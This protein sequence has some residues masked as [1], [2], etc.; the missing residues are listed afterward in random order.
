MTATAHHAILRRD[1]TSFATLSELFDDT[2][3]RH[4]DRPA[5][6]SADCTLT[7]AELKERS[8]ALAERLALNGAGRGDLVGLIADRSVEAVVG[9]LTILRA[10]AAYVPLDTSYPPERM[11][12]MLADSGVSVVVGPTASAG[13]LNGDLIVVDPTQA[14]PSGGDRPGIAQTGRTGSATDLAY[15]IYTSGSTGA[16]KGCLLMHRNVLA[17][18]DGALEHLNVSP[19]DVWSVFHSMSFDVSVFELWGAWTTGGCAALVDLATATSPEA[20]L[21]F[22]QSRG[23][24][25]LSQVP[26]VFRFLSAAYRRRTAPL[27]LRYVLL[28]GEAVDLRVIRDMKADLAAS[29]A[30]PVDFVNLYGITETT[31]H[32]TWKVLDEATLAGDVL[33]PIGLPM[34]HLAIEVRDED[35]SLITDGRDGEMWLCGPGVAAG[36]LNRPDLTAQR[37]VVE[38]DDRGSRTFYRSGDLARWVDGELE[39]L[40]RNDDQVKVRGFRIEVAEI[41]NRLRQ[42]TGVADGA[43]VAKPTRTGTRVL[44]A[45]IVPE[46]GVQVSSEAVRSELLAFL[47]TYMVPDVVKEVRE[48]PLTASGKLDRRSLLAAMS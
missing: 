9:L 32:A 24:T 48:L 12:F 6:L 43:V 33:S 39:Y 36:Y 30:D 14:V 34:K 41:E 23:V 25:V 10:G 1:L 37:F 26:S 38:S 45:V 28:A 3:A 27:R 29:G 20:W 4:P 2:A 11:D 19:E 17:L 44:V 5:L 47:P 42:V 31:V 16:P 35:H 40:G 21:D 18:L 8:I 15:V 13:L 46:D 7:Y 22:C